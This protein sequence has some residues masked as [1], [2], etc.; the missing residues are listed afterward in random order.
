KRIDSGRHSGSTDR[1]RYT[2]HCRPTRET[3]MQNEPTRNEKTGLVYRGREDRVHIADGQRE[4][5]GASMAALLDLRMRQ[6]AERNKALTPG[7]ARGLPLG[8]GCYM[9][10]VYSMA[11]T[12][13]EENGQSLRELGRTL[14]GEFQRL[15]DGEQGHVE[16]VRVIL[17][18]EG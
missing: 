16:E 2:G 4:L 15:A 11:L 6:H 9:T 10:A 17:D 7:P 5:A 14:A 3:T 13:A 1:G 12:L 18:S 8:P